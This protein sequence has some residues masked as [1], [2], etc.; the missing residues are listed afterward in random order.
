[1]DAITTK[2]WIT[3]FLMIGSALIITARR[4][5]NSDGSAGYGIAGWTMFL[6]LHMWW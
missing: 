4:L 2:C 6:I 3:L 5:W 1:M